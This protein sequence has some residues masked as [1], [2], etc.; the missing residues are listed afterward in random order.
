MIEGGYGSKNAIISHHILYQLSPIPV[1]LR[2]AFEPNWQWKFIRHQVSG[3]SHWW[4]W[5]TSSSSQKLHKSILN[6]ISPHYQAC[7]EASSWTW[8]KACSF[9]K[10]FYGGHWICPGRLE[11]ASYS[12]DA[13]WDLKFPPGVIE[14]KAFLRLSNVIQ[15]F[16]PN[17]ALIAAQPNAKLKTRN[18]TNFKTSHLWRWTPSKGYSKTI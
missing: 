4:I 15:R 10:D 5:M 16:I 6:M 18:Q 3:N 1:G 2:H 14:L 7:T 9:V 17:F 8:T 13:I 11:L 12:K